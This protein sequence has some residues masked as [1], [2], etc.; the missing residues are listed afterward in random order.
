MGCCR[1]NMHEQFPRTPLP[2]E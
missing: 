1:G 2:V